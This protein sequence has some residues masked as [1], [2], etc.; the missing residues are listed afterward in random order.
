LTE[1]R[2]T[3]ANGWQLVNVLVESDLETSAIQLTLKFFSF[4]KIINDSLANGN[5]Y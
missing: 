3:H 5:H 4:F 2:S 1:R